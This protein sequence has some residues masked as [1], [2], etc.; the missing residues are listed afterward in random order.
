MPSRRA[1]KG[2]GSL[3][4]DKSKGRYVLKLPYPDPVTG[5]TRYRKRLFETQAQAVAAKRELARQDLPQNGPL[6]TLSVFYDFWATQIAPASRN[7]KTRKDDRNLWLLRIAPA[8]GHVRLDHLT[9]ERIQRWA[10][11]IERSRTR[12]KAYALLRTV[13]NRAVKMRKLQWSPFE[14]TAAPPHRYSEPSILTAEECKRLRQAAEGTLLEGPVRIALALGLRSGEIRGAK[15]S[16]LDLGRAVWKVERQWA[17]T[18]ADT[19]LPKG[20]KKRAIAIP[21]QLLAWLRDRKARASSVFVCPGRGDGVLRDS[22]FGK[23]W[24]RLRQAVAMHE[25]EFRDLRNTCASHMD[26]LNVPIA[27]RL[28]TL[29]HEDFDVTRDHYTRVADPTAQL[30]ALTQLEDSIG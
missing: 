6:E 7:P 14:G 29:G 13:V 5:R 8:L 19:K 30:A 28:A 22:A 2:S 24:R 12:A 20:E 15:W 21:P 16:D 25:L 11:S 26:Q 1:P 3:F 17:E 10:N 4:F 27:V 9:P 18:L 23:A